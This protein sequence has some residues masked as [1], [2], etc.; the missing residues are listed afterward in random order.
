MAWYCAFSGH[1]FYTTFQ[2]V[3]KVN[4][5]GQS[6]SDIVQTFQKTS[7]YVDPFGLSALKAGAKGAIGANGV[8]DASGVN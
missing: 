3:A 7:C 5:H 8:T 2:A 1:Y 4:F 6:T